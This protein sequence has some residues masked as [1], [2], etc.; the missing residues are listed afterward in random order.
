VNASVE[1]SLRAVTGLR[2]NPGAAVGALV[3]SVICALAIFA[4]W[5][6]PYD[7]NEIGVAAP[8][9]SPSLHHWFGTDAFG[10]DLLSRVI[11]G[12]RYSISIGLLTLALGLVSG[13]LL[14]MVLGYAGGRID[15]WGSRL[16]DVM[17]GV[18]GLVIAVMV[19]SIMGVG[20]LNVALAVAIAQLPH[21]ARVV[22]S[23]TL[24]VRRK[25]FI[26]AAVAIGARPAGVLAT[27][28]L[29]NIA[30]TL[31]VVATLNL[32][33]AIL[34]T[35]TLSFLGLGAQPPTPEWGSMLSDGQEYMRYAPWMMLSPGI[36]IFLTVLA[37][38]LLGNHLNERL[39]SGAGR[40]R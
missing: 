15:D 19:V 29:P 40:R 18:P 25:L 33:E 30:P 22:R 31:V 3:L 36:A 17:L 9:A 34:A 26:E 16:I 12:G 35:S 14:G 38:N 1:N 7:W 11:A 39:R 27:H 4:A 20:L 32:G 2:E 10:R 28:I 37:V 21:Y 13:G 24:V 5:L 8:L 6:A 23:A